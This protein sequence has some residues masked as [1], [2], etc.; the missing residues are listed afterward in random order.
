MLFVEFKERKTIFRAGTLVEEI[1]MRDGL[2]T[3][4]GQAIAC[5]YRSTL[6]VWSVHWCTDERDRHTDSVG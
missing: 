4:F 6:G 1:S 2:D 3:L 5:S